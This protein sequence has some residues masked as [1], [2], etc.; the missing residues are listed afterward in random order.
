MSRWCVSVAEFMLLCISSPTSKVINN[1][2][3][4]KRWCDN[5]NSP[6]RKATEMDIKAAL[7]G[8]SPWRREGCMPEATWGL[9]LTSRLGKYL[10]NRT[11]LF[12][13]SS[14]MGKTCK[15]DNPQGRN[16]PFYFCFLKL[17][18]FLTLVWY[19]SFSHELKSFVHSAKSALN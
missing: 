5:R 19:W 1:K 14:S 15:L 17:Y 16:A 9:A 10:H 2:T 8:H 7:R 4:N 6:D 13:P 12:K 11:G 3:K 18:S